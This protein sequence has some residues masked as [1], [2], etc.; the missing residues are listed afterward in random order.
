LAA[1]FILGRTPAASAPEIYVSALQN[2][3][4]Y[5]APTRISST[6][7]APVSVSATAAHTHVPGGIIPDGIKQRI[8]FFRLIDRALVAYVPRCRVDSVSKQ[9]HGLSAL[10]MPHLAID[11][12]IDC[13]VEARTVTEIS[14]ANRVTQC[15]PVVCKGAQNMDPVVK[16][17][18][19]DPIVGSQL[20][21][22]C[23][24]RILDFF[25]AKRRRRTYIDQ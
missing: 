21:K 7:A 22:K 3:T 20:V 19:H 13:L 10:N 24:R 2:R 17:N 9:H 25:N 15:W 11:C 6:A 8:R 16:C 18:Y 1:L 4:Q 12:V 14:L 23:D 5:T